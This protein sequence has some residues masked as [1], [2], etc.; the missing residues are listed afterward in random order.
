MQIRALTAAA[1]LVVVASATAACGP[2]ATPGAGTTPASSAAA[3]GN[4][5]A[6]GAPAGTAASAAGTT[7]AGSGGG[8]LNVCSLMTSAQ[9]S[10]INSVTY[11]AATAKHVTNGYDTCTYT[12]TGT[13][14]SPVDIQ[15]L[16]VTVVSTTS[17]YNELEQADGP[18]VKVSGVGDDAFGYQIGI[19]VK[20][21]N[22]C[23]DV[24]GLT[25]AE[26][27]NDYGPDTAMAKIIIAKL[28]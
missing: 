14:A 26:L 12:N 20:A 23:L 4:P 22:R 3:S 1:G 28:T 19:I 17:C 21:G 25:F 10:S 11:G 6:A 8:T 15:D 5:A 7:V 2:A 13:H 16:T 27:K 18:G 9:A 24:S